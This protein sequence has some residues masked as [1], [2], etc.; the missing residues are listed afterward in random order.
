MPV[1]PQDRPIEALREETVDRLI[2]NYGHGK[3]SREA[4]ERRLD[5]ALDAKSHDR[6]LELVEDLD[7]DVDKQYA[8]QKRAELGLDPASAAPAP[9]EDVEHLINVFGGSNRSGAWDV[10][11][12]IRMLNVFGGAELDFAHAR[13][14]KKATRVRMICVFG[15]AH[16]FVRQDMRIVSKVLSVFGGVSN[17]APSSPDP[18]A[19]T[20]YITGLAFF[21][22]ADIRVKKTA[23]ERL[24]EFAQ[25]FRSMFGSARPPT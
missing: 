1:T 9:I 20:L 24:Q 8:E 2:M 11:A 16:F 18:S 10:P 12:E 17:R 19:P 4:F 23:R 14:S 3:L 25:H 7:L 15:G 22:G 21:G 6:L 13:F 5:D